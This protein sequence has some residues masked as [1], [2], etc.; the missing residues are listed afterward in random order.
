M[1]LSESS[2]VSSSNR[3]GEE[4]SAAGQ[5]K[6]LLKEGDVIYSGSENSSESLSGKKRGKENWEGKENQRLQ[7]TFLPEALYAM[8]T[9]LRSEHTVSLSFSG[10]VHLR[11]QSKGRGLALR[12]E[13]QDLKKS[14][15]L[16]VGR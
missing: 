16:V 14:S 5:G 4:A 3:F 7:L 12:E 13:G 1:D 15:Q 9:K 10:K 6:S 11:H 2:S 8:K